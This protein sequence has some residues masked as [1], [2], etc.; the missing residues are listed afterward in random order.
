MS[1][2][3]LDEVQ[4]MAQE[5]K[6]SLDFMT[7]LKRLEIEISKLGMDKEQNRKQAIHWNLLVGSVILAAIIGAYGVTY[8]VDTNAEIEYKKIELEYKKIEFEKTE[9]EQR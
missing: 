5:K 7:E 3:S 8:T 1:F 9:N 4:D 6:N 2:D